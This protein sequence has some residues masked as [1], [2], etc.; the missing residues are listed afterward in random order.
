MSDNGGRPTK[1]AWVPRVLGLEIQPDRTPAASRNPADKQR[2]AEQWGTARGVVLATLKE[3]ET[4]IRSMNDPLGDAAIILVKAISANL[5]EA[6]NTP[7]QIDAL[8]S[9]LQSDSIID[10]AE[11]PNGFGIEVRIRAPLMVALD[12]IERSMAA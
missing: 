6:P 7:R 5:T 9:Y 2:A 3:L 4:S 8:K 12:A 1:D 10:D 11:S